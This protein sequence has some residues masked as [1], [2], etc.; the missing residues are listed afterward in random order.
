[1]IQTLLKITPYK[2][3]GMHPFQGLLFISDFP[4][5]ERTCRLPPLPASQVCQIP[6]CPGAVFPDR[7]NS[8][9]MK[10][11]MTE[12]MDADWMALLPENT[13]LGKKTCTG[14]YLI[15][16]KTRAQETGKNRPAH[17]RIV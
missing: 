9:L 1:M 2:Q 4:S 13:C 10:S 15:K 11:R 5:L 3:F 14:L 17:D 6:P 16:Q 8:F 12:N 7:T